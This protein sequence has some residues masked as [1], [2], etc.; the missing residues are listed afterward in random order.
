[1]GFFDRFRTQPVAEPLT[2]ADS[3]GNGVNPRHVDLEKLIDSKSI[4]I[5]DIDGNSIVVVEAPSHA[6]HPVQ[7]ANADAVDLKMKLE[8]GRSASAYSKYLR[9]EYNAELRD[10]AGLLKYDRMRRSDAAVR[11]ALKTLKTPVLGATWYVQ[12][13]DDTPRSKEIAKFVERN[14]VQYMSYPWPQVILEALLMLDYGFYIFEKVWDERK[15][16]RTNRVFLRK[17]APR[18]PLDVVEWVFDSNGGPSAVDLYNSPG[19]NDHVRIP[20]DKLAIF[21]HDSEGGDLRGISVLRSAY[22]H[23]YF[24][25][26]LY[27]I[28]AIQKERH[29]IGIPIIKLPPGFTTDDRNKAHELGENLRSNEKAHVV[30]PPFWEVMF[31]KLEGQPVSPIESAEHHNKMIYHNVLAQA[32]YASVTGADT[33]V[34]ELFYK[35]SRHLADMVRSVFNKYVIPQIVQPN[36]GIDDYPELKLRRLGD[37]KEARTISFA[38][39]NAVGAGLLRVDDQLEEWFRDLID[40]PKFDQN[41]YRPAPVKQAPGG[42][43]PAP[44]RVGPPRQAPAAGGMQQ[45]RNAGRSNSGTDQSGG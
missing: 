30:L 12:P 27:K 33:D 24:K 42:S 17:L 6:L 28:D 19:A 13:F 38:V 43:A 10:Q 16:G 44:A 35:S 22:K 7:L 37:T 14:F 20:I 40:A 8:L 18:H 2:I 15:V 25:E 9:E 23:W 29:G 34:M 5:V 41:T 39:R 1:M 36:W 31:A 45:G 26:N 4:D 11:S 21:S 3:N 32:V